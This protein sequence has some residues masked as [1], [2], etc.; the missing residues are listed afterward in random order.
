MNHRRRS[1]RGFAVTNVVLDLGGGL[2][3]LAQLAVD[4]RIA[5]NW[6]GVLGDPGK[7]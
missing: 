3:S 4:A 7:M 6:K 1:T 2:L 5:G